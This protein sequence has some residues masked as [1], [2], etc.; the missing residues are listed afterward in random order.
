MMTIDRKKLEKLQRREAKRFIVEHP[1][2]AAL[3]AKGKESLL[4]GV[5]MNWMTK[6]AGA[7]PVFVQHAK[8]AHFTDVEDTGTSICALVIR[9]R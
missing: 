7:F 8:G 1:R 2:S 9:A 4:G 3:F 5:P 6:W